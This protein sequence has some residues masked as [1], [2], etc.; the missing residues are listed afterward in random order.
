[1]W[2]VCLQVSEPSPRAADT[3][4]LSVSVHLTEQNQVQLHPTHVMY[5]TRKQRSQLHSVL[6]ESDTRTVADYS[7]SGV[8]DTWVL[9]EEAAPLVGTNLFPNV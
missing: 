1:M 7:A 3:E 2:L 4:S 9:E 8:S 6:A 5:V